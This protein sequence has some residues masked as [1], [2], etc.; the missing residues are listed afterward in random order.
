VKRYFTT[1][2]GD[3]KSKRDIL[4]PSQ[5]TQSQRGKVRESLAQEASRLTCLTKETLAEERRKGR[6]KCFY[7]LLRRVRQIGYFK[8][9]L[10]K[11]VTL[12]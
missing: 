10:G 12:V 7:D 5:A 8:A 3:A 6:N 11:A 2:A 1:F 4:R 9:F